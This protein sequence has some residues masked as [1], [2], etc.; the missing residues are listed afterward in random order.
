MSGEGRGRE[1]PHRVRAAS[2]SGPAQ[3][4]APA[5]SEE[6]RQRLQAAVKAERDPAKA[7]PEHSDTQP[8]PGGRSRRANDAAVNPG[9]N[10]DKPVTG[11]SDRSQTGKSAPAGGSQHSAAQERDTRSSSGSNGRTAATERKG[12]GGPSD[13]NTRT[14]TAIQ[15]SSS[16]TPIQPVPRTARR[17]RARL[18]ALA[19]ALVVVLALGVVLIRVIGPGHGDLDGATL[20]EEYS[21][22][23]QTAAW[24]A[25]DVS[26]GISISCDQVMCAA[27]KADS[28]GGKLVVLGPTSPEPPASTLVVV[29]PAVQ[30]LYGTSL[31]AAWAPSVLASFGS[32]TAEISV[33]IIAPHGVGSYQA[34]ARTDQ[35]YRISFGTA[36]LNLNPITLSA[37][38]Q[39][40][41]T[42]G[43]VDQRLLLA[44]AA[45]A[46]KEPIDI[47]DFASNGPGQS[48]D[49]PLRVADR[50]TWRR[51]PTYEPCTSS[52]TR[53][54]P[55]S[56]PPAASRRCRVRSSSASSSVRRP[57]L[58]RSASSCR[59]PG[60]RRKKAPAQES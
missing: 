22:R 50:P 4:T 42:T 55:R 45:L 26:P 12:R 5:L 21:L 17:R 10:R 2:P 6:L 53:P 40:Q 48:G 56:P 11:R 52:W 27:L 14:G 36:L 28:F 15:P 23:S 59:K 32:G 3:S 18:G 46:T 29:T 16:A 43:Q 7:Q 37:S 1:L 25:Q 8:G 30:S 24:V 19:A 35:G 9:V 49:V 41:L 60:R 38:A 54:R 34:Q 51:A 20:S 33:R 31:S 13:G 57:R 47:L 58:A 39:Q 44:L